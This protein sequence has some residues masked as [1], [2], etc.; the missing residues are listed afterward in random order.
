MKGSSL[1]SSFK[2]PTRT[3]GYSMPHWIFAWT[4]IL[5]GLSLSEISWMCL[6]RHDGTEELLW[7]SQGPFSGSFVK[8]RITSHNFEPLLVI[9]RE[10]T[11]ILE[12]TR[13]ESTVISAIRHQPSQG[14]KVFE[15]LYCS[16]LISLGSL[17]YL[18]LL[19]SQSIG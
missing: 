15:S 4:S 3:V 17:N 13:N 2:F 18:T 12:I 19:L 16:G 11:S 5:T 6:V 9:L 7:N 8:D 10:S 14:L 1:A